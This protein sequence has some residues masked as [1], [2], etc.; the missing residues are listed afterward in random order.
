MAALATIIA[1]YL[2][3]Q[4]VPHGQHPQPVNHL[5]HKYYYVLNPMTT[6]KLN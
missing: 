6:I 2:P 1:A 3:Y 4:T 5:K